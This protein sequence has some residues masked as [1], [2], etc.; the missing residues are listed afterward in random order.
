MKGGAALAEDP[1]VDQHGPGGG[2]DEPA[3]V[4]LR[5]RLAGP[6]EPPFASA[7][8]FHPGVVVVAV[9]ILNESSFHTVA[10]L[11]ANDQGE[12]QARLGLGSLHILADWQDLFAEADWRGC[13]R[14][15][16]TG[17]RRPAGRGRP[18]CAGRRPGRRTLPP[19]YARTQ[20]YTFRALANGKP[21]PGARFR[22]QIL[23]ESSFHTV[24]VLTAND[25]KADSSPQRP[26]P[27]RKTV[28][29]EAVRSSWA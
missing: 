12:A 29:G 9:Q 13:R 16:T 24:A 27:Q 8:D 4:Q 7:Q 11:T 28:R 6:Q 17:G 20:I 23:N 25:R 26:L 5:L 1:A 14:S 15:G 10:V 21:A 3:P 2:G 19:R 18:R 22:L